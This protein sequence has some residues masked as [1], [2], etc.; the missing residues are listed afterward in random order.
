MGFTSPLFSAASRARLA[1]CHPDLQVIFNEV[2]RWADCTIICGHR[3]QQDQARAFD[4][5]LTQL[6]WPDSKHNSQPSMAADVA[7]YQAQISNIDWAD[8]PA[9][10]VFKGKVEIIAMQLL[11]A[12]KITHLVRW[13]GDWDTDGRTT[14][15]KFNDLP[16][17]ELITGG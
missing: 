11:G 17:F 9:F 7:P 16:H 1:T 6:K 10:Y 4:A 12:G 3:G 5:D 8:R 13:G 2:I 14:D 15:Q